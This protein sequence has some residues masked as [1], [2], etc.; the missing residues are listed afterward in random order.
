MANIT[1]NM[2]KDSKH[3]VK[4]AHAVPK[5]EKQKVTIFFPPDDVHIRGSIIN[6]LNA[7]EINAFVGG[8]FVEGTLTKDA[9]EEISDIIPLV[10]LFPLNKDS[11]HYIYSY[12]RV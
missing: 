12:S 11:S 10:Y 2:P 5:H 1:Q 6:I 8:N 9:I 3:Y 4:G 7:R